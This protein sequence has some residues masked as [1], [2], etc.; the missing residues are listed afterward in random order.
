MSWEYRNDF[1]VNQILVPM[2]RQWTAPKLSFFKRNSNPASPTIWISVFESAE[3]EYLIEIEIE[4]K[5]RTANP[6]AFSND[7]AVVIKPVIPGYDFEME[8]PGKGQNIE[9]VN[10]LLA[11]MKEPADK[12]AAL[13]D[14]SEKNHPI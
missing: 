8:Y 3:Y 1:A 4:A 14:E 9:T 2:A 12:M 13:I 5:A 10:Y 7:F 6:E 11:N